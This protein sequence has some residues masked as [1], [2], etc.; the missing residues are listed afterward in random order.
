MVPLMDHPLTN[1]PP[2]GADFIRVWHGTSAESAIILCRDGWAPHSGPRG[3]QCGN[4]A[5][6]YVTTHPEDARWFADQKDLGTVLELLIE[7]S[8]LR[9]DPE[10]G[11]GETVAEE[12]EASARFGVPAKLAVHRPISPGRIGVYAPVDPIDLPE[13]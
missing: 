6:L 4:P 7:R 11:V 8:S 9:V 5:L 1:G 3:S 10:D 13:P 12:L 2:R